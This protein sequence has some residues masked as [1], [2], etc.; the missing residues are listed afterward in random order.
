[1]EQTRKTKLIA[2][3]KAFLQIPLLILIFPLAVLAT[4]FMALYSLIMTFVTVYKEAKEDYMKN[5]QE[6]ELKLKVAATDERL[7]EL[8]TKLNSVMLMA[9]KK[10][11][12]VPVEEL[13]PLFPANNSGLSFSAFVAQYLE[14]EPGLFGVKVFEDGCSISNNRE[15]CALNFNELFCTVNDM[16]SLSCWA[17]NRNPTY[18]LVP[19]SLYLTAKTLIESPMRPDGTI[20]MF[21]NSLKVVHVPELTKVTT[22]YLL[23]EK[24]ESSEADWSCF[25]RA[26][27]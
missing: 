26:K 24:P 3:I 5:A 27:A 1:M 19:S 18:L 12:T 13:A 9:N 22:W 21:H 11:V 2:S 25:Y 16:L 7:A 15:C 8:E 20:N 14:N 17:I 10:D 23:A 6:K 4:P